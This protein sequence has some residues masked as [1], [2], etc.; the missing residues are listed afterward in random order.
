MVD[1]GEL[2]V[3]GVPIAAISTR[4]RKANTLSKANG[5]SQKTSSDESIINSMA[6][7]ERVVLKEFGLIDVDVMYSKLKAYMREQNKLDTKTPFKNSLNLREEETVMKVA[8]YILEK[9]D[10]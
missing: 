8:Q 5:S 6:D 2:A 4:K 7:A 10:N 3:G 9:W 1:D